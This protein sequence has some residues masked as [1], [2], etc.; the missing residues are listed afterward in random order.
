MGRKYTEQLLFSGFAALLL[1]FACSEQ[2]CKLPP[3]TQMKELKKQPRYIYPYTDLAA[4][5]KAQGVSTLRL[6]IYGSLMDPQSRGG[7]LVH[8]NLTQEQTALA[9]GVQRLFNLDVAYK[10]GSKWGPLTTPASRGML[11]IRVTDNADEFINGVIVEVALDDLPLLSKRETFYD[12]VPI[13][14]A[15]WKSFLYGKFS[16]STA[17]ILAAP[18]KPGITSATILPRDAYFTFTR[19]A[20]A[21]YGSCFEDFWLN[22]TYLAD[23]ITPVSDWLAKQPAAKP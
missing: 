16:F 5:L 9:F 1:L 14:T 15:D 11:N 20:A 13:I 23:G 2:D 18:E 6:F 10:P 7:T 19:A 4:E 3:P 22:T 17:Y 21:K 12:L 8:S